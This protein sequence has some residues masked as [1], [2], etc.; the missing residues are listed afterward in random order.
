MK[1]V[2]RFKLTLEDAKKMAAV[3]QRKAE[4]MGKVCSF[5]V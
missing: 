4:E 1:Q 5:A 3:A 2:T